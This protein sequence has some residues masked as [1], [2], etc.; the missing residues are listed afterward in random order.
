MDAYGFPIGLFTTNRWVTDE[1]WY[2][3]DDATRM[4]AHFRIDH[5]GP[6]WPVNRWLSAM[7]MLFRPQ[8]AAL[9]AARDAAIAAWA[10]RQPG[11]DVFEDRNLEVASQLSISVEAQMA[12]LRALPGA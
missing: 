10:A 12:R 7:F 8:M 9:L 6:S 4:L 3:A 2:V 5:A 11:V 1:A